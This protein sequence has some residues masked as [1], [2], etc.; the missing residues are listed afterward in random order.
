[1]IHQPPT[2]LQTISSPWP[3]VKWGI[4]IGQRRFLIV[5]VDYFIKWIEVEPLAK[6]MA[7]NVQSFMWKIVCRFRVPHI[8]MTDNGRQ[9]VDRKL[10]SFLAKLGIKHIINS[11]EH[12]QMNGQTKAANKVILAQI[13]KRLSVA[14]GKW[15]NKLLEVLWAYRCTPQTS[16]GESPYNL[17]YGTDIMLPIEIGEATMRK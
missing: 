12:P 15:K 5:V 16:I 3:F 1:L 13:K 10:E 7:T 6:I 8:I 4:D 2:D 14:K 11:V 9:F 17:T